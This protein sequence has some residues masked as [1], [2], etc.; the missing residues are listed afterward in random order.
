MDRRKFISLAMKS[1]IGTS[2]AFGA[3]SVFSATTGCLVNQQEVFLPGLA[4]PFD[5][6]RIAFVSDLHH[7]PWITA[8]Y[9]R[10]T[11]LQ[12]NALQPDLIALGGDYIHRGAEWV[13]GCMGELSALRAKSGVCGVL[14]NHD[15]YKGAAPAVS[16]A[17]RQAGI[18]ELTNRGIALQRDGTDLWIGGVGDYQKDKQDLKAALSG[19]RDA[20]SALLLSHN[21]DY[22]EHVHDERVGLALSGHTHGGQCVFPLIGAPINPSAYGDKYLAGLCEG[23]ACPVFVTRGMGASF[24]PIRI[25][26]PAE[27]VLLTLR[28]GMPA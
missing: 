17:L 27:I 13:P 14:G 4:R 21:P 8:P 15:H 20:K 26:C 12:I 5:G 2:V 28:R 22:I 24:P 16:A 25:M 11:V 3:A 6:F 7:S 1:A 23:P 18:E 9:I 10:K 19:A